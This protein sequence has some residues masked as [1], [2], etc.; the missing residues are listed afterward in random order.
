MRNIVLIHNEGKSR[1]AN[2]FQSQQQRP[3]L[4]DGHAIGLRLC[5][6]SHKSQL[7]NGASGKS[8]RTLGLD[9]SRYAIMK[10]M[11]HQSQCDQS[12][13]IE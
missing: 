12:I 3:C 8:R 13:Y 9:P 7:C 11:M 5:Q 2:S 4:R 10:L 6:D 1:R